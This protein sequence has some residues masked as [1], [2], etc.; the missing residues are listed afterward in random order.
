M[1]TELASVALIAILYMAP[2]SFHLLFMQKMSI[3]VVYQKC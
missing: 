1:Q 3:A 2:D